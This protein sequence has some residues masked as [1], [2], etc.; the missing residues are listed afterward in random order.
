MQYFFVYLL[1]R[2]VGFCVCVCVCV[3]GGGVEGWVGEGL[4]GDDSMVG[5]WA[6]LF[7]SRFALTLG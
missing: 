5:S 7:K 3:G 1:G 6:G 2:M 4:E